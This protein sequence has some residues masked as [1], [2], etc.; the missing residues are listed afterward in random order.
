MRMSRFVALACSVAAMLFCGPM[1]FAQNY[2][3]KLVRIVTSSP[4]NL[5]DTM[6]RIVAQQLTKSLG[7][8]VIVENR[9]GAVIPVETVLKAA[10]DG[11]TLLFVSDSFI[12]GPF[13]QEARYDP[14]KDFSP[15]ALVALSPSILVVIPSLA[16]GSVK[17][18]I[19]LS[20]VRPGGLNYGSSS[21]GSTSHTAMEL[22]KIMA[23]V[24]MVRVPYRGNAEAI[25]AAMGAEVQVL[26]Q[27]VPLA[28][29]QIKTGRLKALAVTSAQPSPLVPDLPTVAD[30]LPGYEAQSLLGLVAPAN[31]P[32]AIVNQ[33]NQEI[34]RMLQSAEVRER[35]STLGA[36][37]VGNSPEQF[38]GVLKSAVS[39][40]ANIIKQTGLKLE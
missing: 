10:P 5:S 22:F 39:R 35:L 21:N 40:L 34:V 12:G 18:L 15:V 9:P 33:L 2:P 29:P 28:L 37:P 3:G 36:Q 17:E 31:T 19:T 27:T 20:K 25:S 32:A 6:A 1:V 4:G 30:T 24:S 23:G 26:M 38:S 13:L 14:Q 16:V 7:Q 11:Y 8:Q